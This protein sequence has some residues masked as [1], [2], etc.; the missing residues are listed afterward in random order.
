MDRRIAELEN[1]YVKAEAS[2]RIRRVASS[3]CSSFLRLYDLTAY[4]SPVLY[5]RDRYQWLNLSSYGFNNRTSSYKVGACNSVF[6]DYSNGGGALY[7]TN[8]T[9]AYDQAS[10]MNSGWNNDVSSVYIG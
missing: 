10:S 5:L 8:L 3:T 7:P 6:A 2:Q 4:R 9:Q 1:E